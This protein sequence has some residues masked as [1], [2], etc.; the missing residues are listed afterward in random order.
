M[1]SRATTSMTAATAF[2]S[3]MVRRGGFLTC[4]FSAQDGQQAKGRLNMAGTWLEPFG[5]LRFQGHVEHAARDASQQQPMWRLMGRLTMANIMKGKPTDTA[6]ASG[7]EEDSWGARVPG[8]ISQAVIG[9]KAAKPVL[10]WPVGDRA[11][12]PHTGVEEGLQIG[13]KQTVGRCIAGV[14]TS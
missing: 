10:T 12:E 3:R 5:A 13:E 9:S 11:H 6:R 2:I 4:R 8:S 7:G 14:G 1:A